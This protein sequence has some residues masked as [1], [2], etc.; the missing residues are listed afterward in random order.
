MAKFGFKK[1]FEGDT[2]NVEE[3]T[4]GELSGGQ[5]M[6]L[7]LCTLQLNNPHVILFDEPT[8]HLD[9]YSIEQ[10][11]EAINNFNGGCVIIT[12]DN[13]LIENINNYELLILNNKKLIKFKDDF[14]KYC[15][16]IQEYE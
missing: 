2:Y 1:T 3:L 6:K 16:L 13:Y 12:H 7:V 11:V 8:N 10:F 9:I 15:E 14:N 5:K 4:I